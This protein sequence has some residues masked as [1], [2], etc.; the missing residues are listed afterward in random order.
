[1]QNVFLCLALLFSWP[2]FGAGAPAP[3]AKVEKLVGTAFYNGKEIH[4]GDSLSVNGT[5]ETKKR[6][7]LRIQMDVWNSSIVIGPDTKMTLDLTSPK[8]ANPK[9]Y[10]LTDG[11]CRWVSAMKSSQLKGSHV[12]T[13]SASLGVRGTDFEIRN[14][15]ASGETEVIVFDGEVLLKSNL[16][17]SEALLK[18]GQWGGVGGKFGATIAKPVDLSPADLKMAKERSE[19]LVSGKSPES[20]T[21]GESPPY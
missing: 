16:A 7:F 17:K 10:Q 6:S 20:S 3:S 5:L 15:V 8:E 19:A 12:F 2:A 14:R 11:L 4:E 1:M 13:K 9:R 21:P 18:K